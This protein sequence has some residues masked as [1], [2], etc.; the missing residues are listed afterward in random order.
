MGHQVK[1][2]SVVALAFASILAACHD[3]SEPTGPA[4]PS[5]AFSRGGAPGSGDIPL[6]FNPDASRSCGFPVYE[7]FTGRQKLLELPGGRRL[8]LYPGLT[9]TFVNGITGASYTF[10]STGTFRENPLPNGGLEI[11]IT[12]RGPVGLEEN[13]ALLTILISGRYTLVFGPDGSIVQPLSGVGGRVDL[14]D[15]LQ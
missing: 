7:S 10:S 4:A 9:G 3:V 14:C 6:R 2:P 12:G 11:V 8:T 5:P 13:G 15:V 1:L